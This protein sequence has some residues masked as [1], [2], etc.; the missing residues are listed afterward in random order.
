[1][2]KTKSKI[3][4]ENYL[5]IQGWMVNEFKLKGNELLVYATI[6]GFSQEENQAFSG[7]LQ[8]L[9]DWTNSSKESVRKCL[10]SLAEKGLIIKGEEYKN[11]VKFCW[12][13]IARGYTTKLVGVYNK[14]VLII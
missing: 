8:Y 4:N 9:A 11:E 3:S 10:K 6:Y 13:S 12:Y 14:V 5:V 7:S 1:M 2:E